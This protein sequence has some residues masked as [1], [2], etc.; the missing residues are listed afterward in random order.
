MFFFVFVFSLIQLL[1][2]ILLCLLDKHYLKCFYNKSIYYTILHRACE[3]GNLQTVEYILSLKGID[4]KARTIG[5][6]YFD[7]V[8]IS[9][10]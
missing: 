9:L 6:L 8:S 2:R 3:S 4:I 10:V 1:F 7:K 5:H